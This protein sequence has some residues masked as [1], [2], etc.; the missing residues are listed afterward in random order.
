MPNEPHNKIKISNF[1]GSS[2]FQFKEF[3]VI[4]KFTN[5]VVTEIVYRQEK[6]VKK[7]N[8]LFKIRDLLPLKECI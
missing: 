8:R 2:L 6:I 7:L 1:R 5:K 4:L 3:Q